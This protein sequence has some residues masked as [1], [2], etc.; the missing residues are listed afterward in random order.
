M[1]LQEEEKIIEY[2]RWDK[3]ICQNEVNIKAKEQVQK[4]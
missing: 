4:Y 3:R 1:R 2:G